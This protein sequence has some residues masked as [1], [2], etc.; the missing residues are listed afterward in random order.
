MP[1]AYLHGMG[2]ELMANS[3]N[4]LRCGLTPKHVDVAGLLAVTDFRPAEPAVLT[5]E[6]IA[7]GDGTETHYPS[8]AAEFHLSRLRLAGA[9]VRVDRAAVPQILLCTSGEARL[10]APD[11]TTLA[12][13]RGRSAYLRPTTTPVHLTGPGAELFRATVGLAQDAP[14]GR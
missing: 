4:V 8:P 7:D 12:L 5:G 9:P 10:H 14:S 1:H 2:V 11:G 3:D 6:P 13:P